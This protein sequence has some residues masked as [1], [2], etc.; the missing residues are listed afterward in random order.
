MRNPQQLSDLLTVTQETYGKVGDFCSPTFE[1]LPQDCA[2]HQW[3][4]LIMQGIGA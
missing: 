1:L 4:W 2:S 3:L